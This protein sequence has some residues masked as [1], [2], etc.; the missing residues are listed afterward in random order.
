MKGLTLK[1]SLNPENWI[2]VLSSFN[3]IVFVELNPSNEAG[4]IGK[5]RWVPAELTQ[6]NGRGVSREAFVLGRGAFQIASAY[7]P[8]QGTV[9]LFGRTVAARR[10]FVP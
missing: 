9:E 6:R 5:C 4:F 7:S 8:S 10:R 3:S 2:A 1:G